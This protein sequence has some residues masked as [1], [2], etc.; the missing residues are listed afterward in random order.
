M[1]KNKTDTNEGGFS[2]NFETVE[3][4]PAAR[5]GTGGKSKYDWAAFPPPDKDGNVTMAFVEGVGP[6]SL[7]TSIRKYRMKVKEAGGEVPEFTLRRR[8]DEATGEVAGT[9]VYRAK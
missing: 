2:F 6:K 4:V 9:E 8:M 5:G 1:T 3:K 7:Y